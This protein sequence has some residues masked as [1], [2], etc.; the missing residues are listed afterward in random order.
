ME[1]TM[2]KSLNYQITIPN[3]YKF[4]KRFLNAAH[5]NRNLCY[6]ASY[7]IE[8]SLLS[9]DMIKKYKPSQLA[10]AAIL[11]ARDAVGRNPWSPTLLKCSE[12]REEDVL[13]VS[14]DMLAAKKRS[15]MI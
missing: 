5:A 1:E 2:L 7:I 4:L 15:V 3:A 6:L 12:Y 11:I 8:G 14:H 13:P 9:Y 10:A